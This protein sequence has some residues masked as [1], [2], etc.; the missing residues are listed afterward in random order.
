M[1]RLLILLVGLNWLYSLAIAQTQADTANFAFAPRHAILVESSWFILS[2]SIL[3]H[4]V[5]YEYEYWRSKR[6]RMQMGVRA[7]AGIIQDIP[8]SWASGLWVPVVNRFSFG[9]NVHRFEA[10]LGASFLTSIFLPVFPIVQ[11]GY[12]FQPPKR[13]TIWRA[14]LGVTGVGASVG[15]AF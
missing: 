7:G 6:G 13:G 3:F 5:G 2:S 1:K 9:A 8:D 4:S 15:W 14:H 10:V 11:L 12:R